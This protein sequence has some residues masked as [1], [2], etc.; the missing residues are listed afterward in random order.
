LHSA[1]RKAS[2]EVASHDRRGA[3][4][5]LLR[6]TINAFARGIGWTLAR[7]LFR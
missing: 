5:R 7:K 3:V 1:Q 4:T 6:I 2:R